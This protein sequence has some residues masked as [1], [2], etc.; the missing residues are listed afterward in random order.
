MNTLNNEINTALAHYITDQ[1]TI[2][3]AVSGGGDSMALLVGLKNL[4]KPC[5][6]IALTVNHNLR[7]DAQLEA[8]QVKQWCSK[9]AIEHHILE[10]QFNTIPQTA[11]QEKARNAR[12]QLMG[13]FCLKHNISQLFVGHNL[14]DNAETF[15]MRLKRGA[16]LR[17]LAAIAPF[18]TRDNKLDI[19]RP[20]LNIKRVALR[21]YL[22]SKDQQWL[23]DVSNE[24]EKYERVKIRKFLN[25]NAL[26]NSDDIAK[27]AVRLKR[28][29]NALEFYVDEFCRNKVF[30]LKYGIAK[31]SLP[32]FNKLPDEVKLRILARLI[33][34]IGK[35]YSP[36]RWQKIEHLLEQ[37][38]QNTSTCLGNCL[39]VI[40]SDNIW[41]GYE[42]RDKDTP[43]KALIALVKSNYS[44]LADAPKKII[45]T[46]PM[47]LAP[48]PLI[49]LPKMAIKL[50]C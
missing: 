37:V 28:A 1:T 2:A 12:Y 46:L 31:V 19:I 48:E 41:F 47:I 20:F 32:D 26:L 34:S 15:I 40:N 23:D 18:S 50:R 33:W 9:M 29:D 24:D 16:G 44:E 49:L 39:M 5:K 3:V 35:K 36:P 45:A 4:Q 25:N 27:S 8:M 22:E 7:Q 6:I 10:W 11:I 13:D 30:F 38:E 17:G 42:V 43:D 14:E 21:Q